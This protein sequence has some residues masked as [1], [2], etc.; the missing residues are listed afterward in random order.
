MSICQ[1]TERTEAHLEPI[2][3]FFFGIRY[4]E[5]LNRIRYNEF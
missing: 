1:D 5:F 2:K 3:V 4:N